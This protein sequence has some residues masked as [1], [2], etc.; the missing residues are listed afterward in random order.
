MWWIHDKYFYYVIQIKV[1]WV[2]KMKEG[3]FQKI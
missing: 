3:K 2:R 1:S